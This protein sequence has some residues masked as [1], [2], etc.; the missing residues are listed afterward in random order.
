M[1]F[2]TI[3]LIAITLSM[4]AFTLSISYGML[5]IK[6]SMIIRVSLLVGVFHFFMPLIGLKL[7]SFIYEVIDIKEDLLMGIIF[8]ILSIDLLINM[9]KDKDLKGI[10][11]NIQ[12]L[13]FSLAV[14]L[15]SLT[16]GITLNAIDDRI[17]LVTMVFMIVSAIFTLIG[18]FF[19]KMIKKVVGIKAEI[20]GVIS[21][22][23]L[24]IYYIVK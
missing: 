14:S 20:V 13:L 9:F 8:L 11:D 5:N 17:F 4:D 23:L 15:D 19:G 22:M 21:L 2:F 18:L 3:L 24:A 6:K 16:V 1:S 12:V 7:G 10:N